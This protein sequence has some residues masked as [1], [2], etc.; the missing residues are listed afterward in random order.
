MEKYTRSLTHA[1][2]AALGIAVLAIATPAGQSFVVNHP[3]L[4][5]FV[6]LFVAVARAVEAWKKGH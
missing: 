6:P 2:Y 5:G 1:L 4:A 3:A